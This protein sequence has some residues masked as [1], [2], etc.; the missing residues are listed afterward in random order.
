MILDSCPK[1]KLRRS[2]LKTGR[3]SNGGKH[4]ATW[5][6]R[7]CMEEAVGVQRILEKDQ[8]V[9]ESIPNFR[10]KNDRK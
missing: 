3:L 10:K 1:E 7:I 5:Q 9:R 4:A 8:S 6:T 2:S